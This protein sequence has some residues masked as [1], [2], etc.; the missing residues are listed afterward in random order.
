MPNTRTVEVA[1]GLA[2]RV[3]ILTVPLAWGVRSARGSW[4]GTYG[5][6]WQ[7]KCRTLNAVHR[8]LLDSQTP[9][10]GQVAP[11]LDTPPVARYLYQIT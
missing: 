1:D 6:T 7:S 5:Q 8:P 9:P 10:R 4:F 11:R 2:T 3:E